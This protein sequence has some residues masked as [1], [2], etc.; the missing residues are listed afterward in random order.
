M[1]EFN[2][3]NLDTIYKTLIERDILSEYVIFVKN[4]LNHRLYMNR[5]NT[6]GKTQKLISDVRCDLDLMHVNIASK[7]FRSYL[8]YLSKI[9]MTIC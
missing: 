2:I 5:F 9:S 8:I 1:E 7:N 3:D 4:I 6:Y